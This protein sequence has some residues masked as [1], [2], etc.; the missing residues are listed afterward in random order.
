MASELTR[1]AIKRYS[2]GHKMQ[3][4]VADLT[5]SQTGQIGFYGKSPTLGR[6]MIGIIL[7]CDPSDQK[8]VIWCEDQ[9]DLA[10]LSGREK[11]DVPEPF[12]EVGDVVEFD[13][14][15]LRNMRLALNPTR[16]EHRNSGTSLSEGLRSVPVMENHVVSNTA[17]VIPFRVDHGPRVAASPADRQKLHG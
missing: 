5:V 13:V 1:N 9:G 10:Y 11:V 12:F 7:W 6:N 15:T 16:V 17:K 2:C 8:A 14:Q 4:C 3:A